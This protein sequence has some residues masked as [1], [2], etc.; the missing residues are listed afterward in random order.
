MNVSGL[1]N[2][3]RSGSF[4]SMMKNNNTSKFI[5]SHGKPLVSMA[6]SLESQPSRPAPKPEI[7][8]DNQIVKRLNLEV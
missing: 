8:T 4:S 1:G 5:F 2:R 6:E 3:N 7:F